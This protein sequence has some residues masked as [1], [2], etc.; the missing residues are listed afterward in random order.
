MDPAKI[1]WHSCLLSHKSWC[2]CTEPRNHLPGWPTSEGTSTEDGDIITDAE[3][4]TL[5]EDTE[6]LH[7]TNKPD[8]P[9]STALPINHFQADFM[10]AFQNYLSPHH[11]KTLIS[12]PC[13][14]ATMTRTESSQKKV[15]DALQTLLTLATEDILSPPSPQ[16]QTRSRVPAGMRG[17]WAAKQLENPADAEKDAADHRRRRTRRQLRYRQRVTRSPPYP[18]LGEPLESSSSSDS[19]DAY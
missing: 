11:H 8:K 19:L 7:T 15:S 5:A 2:N 16:H 6:G 1:W 18:D 13:D 17:R 14:P 4:L 9:T 12:T 10:T 3:M